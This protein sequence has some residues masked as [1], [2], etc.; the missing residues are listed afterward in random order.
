MKKDLRRCTSNPCSS[1]CDCSELPSN[2]TYECK[3]PY[4]SPKAVNRAGFYSTLN[5]LSNARPGPFSPM[6]NFINNELN[7]RSMTSTKLFESLDKDD[8]T[9]TRKQPCVDFNPCKHGQCLLNNK[10]GEFRCECEVGYMGPFCDLIR[11]PCDFKP[12]EN[13]ICEIVG[14]LYYKCLCRPN[15]TGV[16]C[17]IEI[18]PCDETKCL[19]GGKCKLDDIYGSGCDCPSG[20]TGYFC[21][22]GN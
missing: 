18:K 19:N 17:H 16:N 1:E 22:T 9:L 13:G 8:L 12:C 2:M 21:E 11:H 7:S 10:T 5:Y 14:D 6:P 3:C 4:V 15:W 20:F